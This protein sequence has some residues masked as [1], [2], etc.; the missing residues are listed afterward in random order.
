MTQ[1]Q[2]LNPIVKVGK[3]LRA[4]TSL[5]MYGYVAAQIFLIFGYNRKTDFNYLLAIINDYNYKDG[6]IY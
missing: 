6:I 2:L 5:P 1:T 4:H 3:L